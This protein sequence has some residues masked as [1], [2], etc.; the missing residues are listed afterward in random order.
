MKFK[1]YSTLYNLRSWLV[2]VVGAVFFITGFGYAFYS[3]I[4]ETVLFYKNELP[5]TSGEAIY[6]I[7]SLTI[8]G[9]A[10]MIVIFIGYFLCLAGFHGVGS[11]PVSFY[12]ELDDWCVKNGVD[13]DADGIGD[14]MD[15]LIKNNLPVPR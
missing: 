14:F 1:T 3:V 6:I 8:K 4:N 7:V 2:I 15:Y 9:L 12:K 13:K 11:H 10:A 5:N